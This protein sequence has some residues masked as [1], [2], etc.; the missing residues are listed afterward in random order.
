M[1]DAGTPP[2]TSDAGANDDDAA[3]SGN[4]DAGADASKT[5]YTEAVLAD[6]PLAYFRLD[7]G[8]GNAV[9]LGSIGDLTLAYGTSVQR[10][11]PGL[12]GDGDLAVHFD[13]TA[14]PQKEL[15]SAANKGIEPATAISL[16]CWIQRDG[17]SNNGGNND[18]F[19]YLVSYDQRGGPPFQSYVLQ[20]NGS[21]PDTYLAN[22]GE[23]TV[24]DG[25]GVAD[26]AIYHLVTTYDGSLVIIYINGVEAKRDAH[27][28]PLAYDG[29]HGLDVGGNSTS[30]NS[31]FNGTIDEVAIYG[32]ALSPERIAAHYAAGIAH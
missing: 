11:A 18:Q 13:G 16:E 22:I 27:Q 25:G 17:G 5:P 9:N 30:A 1:D 28:S 10:G 6:K 24:P 3:P 21:V 15:T 8:T 23:S 7:E 29:Q 32:T 26:H 31:V 20:L 19:A 4:G 14:G 12:I 2:S